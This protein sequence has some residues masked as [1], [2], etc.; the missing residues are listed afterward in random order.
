MKSGKAQ[1]PPS[2]TPNRSSEHR[3]C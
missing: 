2:Q 3:P 1:T